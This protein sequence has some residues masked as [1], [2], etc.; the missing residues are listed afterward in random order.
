MSLNLNGLRVGGLSVRSSLVDK[1]LQKR[2]G[3]TW[4]E[5]C[6]DQT[7]SNALD[8][9]ITTSQPVRIIRS[10]QDRRRR[11][12]GQR[13]GVTVDIYRQFSEGHIFMLTLTFPAQCE[14]VHARAGQDIH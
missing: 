13:E 2:S 12:G 10:T 3:L 14:I 9:I 4:F 8:D 11:A 6:S 5:S 1:K 7:D